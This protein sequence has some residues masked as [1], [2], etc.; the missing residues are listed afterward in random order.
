MN[1]IQLVG[2]FETTVFDNQQNTEVWASAVTHIGNDNENLVQIHHSIDE[3]FNY[4]K[5][6]KC[7][8]DIFYHNLKFDGNFWLSFLFLK[9]GY[10]HAYD[11]ESKTFYS[12]K[13][14]PVK[15][16]KYLI[17]NRGGWYQI[18]IKVSN[19]Q[20]ITIKDSLKLL[21]FSVKTIGK[22]F[23]TKHKKLDMEYKGFRYAGCEITENERHYIANDVLVIAE[24]LKIMFDEGHNKMTI[25]A[26]CMSEFKRGF[27][28][29]EFEYGYFP[30]LT[31]IELTERYNVKTVEEYIRYSYRGAWTYL[32]EE[33]A[34][35]V[36]YN[37]L[38]LDVNSL[39]PSMMSS[40]SGNIFPIGRPHFWCGDYIP[41]KAQENNNFY[42]IRIKTQFKL[43]KGKLPFIQIKNNLLYRPTEM[44]KTSDIYD[45]KSGNYYEYYKDSNGNTQKAIVTLTL[46]QED[47]KLILEHYDLYNFKI[48]DGCYF[49]G[50]SGLFDKYIEKY[51]KIKINSTGAKR[52]L[53]KLFLNNLYG[54]FA[55]S[56]DSSFKVAY[57]KEDKSIGLMEIVENNKK[58]GYIPIG[59]AITSYARC[60][61]IRHAQENYHGVDKS[62]FIYA[63]TDSIHCDLKESEIVNINM[64]PTN[65][66]CWGVE[67]YW[68][69]GI[70]VRPKTYLEEIETKTGI[71]THIT[72]A[73][74]P[75]K[76]KENFINKMNDITDFKVGLSVEGKLRPV[77]INGGVVLQD[78]PYVMR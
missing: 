75:D 18:T 30:D 13:E 58:S 21:P 59:S 29:Q 41:E 52:Q 72:C 26:C 63:D 20:I 46:T 70:F 4:L 3:T 54:K 77:R 40:E 48:L 62:G 14:M 16:F 10:I 15:S 12:D 55:T 2:D 22:S 1:K 43:K 65:F 24:A 8:V 9:S 74:M 61:T 19:R 76:A 56:T 32:V 57:I 60:F 31:K 69:R 28:K 7:N 34:N 37:G 6:F 49:A 5:N 36:F 71:E 27:D 68:K 44:L 39:Y 11:K 53:A 78:T 73:G 51:K 35:K 67:C 42:F 66:L 50:E 47:Y 38:T 25:G 33:K 17:S 45:K 64:H 23:D